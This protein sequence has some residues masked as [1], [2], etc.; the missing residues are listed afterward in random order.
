MARRYTRDNRGRFASVGATARGG[1]LRTAAGN[2]RETVTGR[3]SGV[4][5]KGTIGKPK[6]LK[7]NPSTPAAPS[8]PARRQRVR[9]NF[10]PQN[11]YSG[12]DRSGNKGYGTDAKANVAEARRR[13][14][15]AGAKSALKSNKRSS[16]VASVNERTPST[17]DVN[18]SHTA[19]R[20]P[21]ADMIKSRRKNE[22]STSSANHYVA[23][24][25]GHVRNP[26]KAPNW[27]MQNLKKGSMTDPGP[28]LASMKTALR[29]SRYA[30]KSPAEFAA[31]VSAGRRLGKKYDHQVM[32]Q[33]AEV[34][35]RKP[36][37]LRSQLNRK[38]K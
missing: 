20:N 10:R 28:D 27:K 15:A 35:G 30:T 23:H 26:V 2:K 1:R 13:I 18:A 4:Q 33:F 31:E 9:G 37:N 11:L 16:S 3:L 21:R 25:L 38:R 12:T 34:T 8:G 36:R 19:W 32:K 5:P 24:E 17:V 29:V 7:P 14:E 6:G 22:F